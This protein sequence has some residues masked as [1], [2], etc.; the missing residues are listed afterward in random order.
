MDDTKLNDASEPL[1]EAEI[2]DAR[3]DAAVALQSELERIAAM[4]PED[5][6]EMQANKPQ[7]KVEPTWDV[8]K[9][10]RE[11]LVEALKEVGAPKQMVINASV[12]KYD[13]S[14][15]EKL[16]FELLKHGKVELIQRISAGE[17]NHDIRDVEPLIARN[18]GLPKPPSGPNR[19][20][21]R[22][23]AKYGS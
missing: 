8:N 11:R 14:G 4:S 15:R 9:P 17:F 12:G 21:R 16:I 18:A 22:A 6:L 23:L 13:F 5:A 10:T 3:L 1:T 19:K 20:Q 7:I 2:K